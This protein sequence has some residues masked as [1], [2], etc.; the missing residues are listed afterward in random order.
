[1]K[2]NHN[3]LDAVANAFNEAKAWKTATIAMGIVSVVLSFGLLYKSANQPVVLVPHNFAAEKGRVQVD[4]AKPLDSSAEYL[5]TIAISD[6]ALILNWTPEN[7]LTQYQRFL[8]RASDELY[9]RENIR[10][11]AEAQEHKDN[12]I[13][14]S[15]FPNTV[16]LDLSNKKVIAE[17]FLIRW[18]GDKE[19]IRIKASFILTYKT[20]RGLLYVADLELKKN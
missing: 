10:L 6:L 12:G 13:T 14:Q 9:A 3:Y 11:S 5:Q 19:S 7:V 2:K 15:F 4:P 20:A 16:R 8:N 1:M 18:V 17:G